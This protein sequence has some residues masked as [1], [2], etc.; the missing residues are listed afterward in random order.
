MSSAKPGRFFRSRARSLRGRRCETAGSSIER[1]LPIARSCAESL[2]RRVLLSATWVTA[3][4]PTPSSNPSQLTDVKGA[5]FFTANH[6]DSG[7]GATVGQD[8]W[9]TDGT[10]A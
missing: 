5:T 8:L 2:E 9:K 1:I 6:V 10:D 3:I 4:N 7:T